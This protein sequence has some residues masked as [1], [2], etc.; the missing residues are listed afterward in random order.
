MDIIKVKSNEIERAA[1]RACQ[2]ATIINIKDLF[3]FGT[4]ISKIFVQS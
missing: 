4:E 3:Y 1:K 2:C